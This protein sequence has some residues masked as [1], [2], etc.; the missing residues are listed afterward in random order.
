MMADNN[1]VTGNV[2]SIQRR[3]AAVGREMCIATGPTVQDNKVTNEAI[4]WPAFCARLA[5]PVVTNETIKKYLSADRKT[6]DR[7]K[8]VGYYVFG[9]FKGRRKKENLEFRDA[10]TLDLDHLKPGWRSGL[11]GAFKGLTYAIHSTHKH[12]PEAPRLRQV[13]PLTR[14]VTSEEYEPIARKLAQRFDIN[15]YDKTTFQYNRVMHWPSH[16][17]DAEYI[18]E[19]FGGA[20]VDPDEILALY[21]D[22]TDVD[23]WPAHDGV[24]VSHQVQDLAPD[25]R[26]KHG[27]VGAFCRAFSISEAMDKFIPD[28]YEA[29]TKGRYSYTGGTTSNGAVTYENDLFLYSHHETD[30]CSG[31]LVNAF[32]MVRLHLYGELDGRTRDDTPI[33]KKP[34]YSALVTMLQADPEISRAVAAERAKMLRDEFDAFDL[35]GEEP[36][37]PMIP[38][39]LSDLL[40]DDEPPKQ[41]VDDLLGLDDD[42]DSPK[43]TTGY[44]PEVDGLPDAITVASAEI[45]DPQ[46]PEDWEAQLAVERS[47]LFCN[48]LS[49]VALILAYD[50]EWGHNVRFN[51]FGRFH[52]M[53]KPLA[54]RSK[55][56]FASEGARVN[57]SVFSDRDVPQVKLMLEKKYGMVKIPT[58]MVFGAVE[59]VGTKNRFHPVLSYFSSLPAWDGKPRMESLLI[60]YLGAADNEYTRAV[61]RKVLCAAINRVK[62]PGSKWDYLLILEGLQGVRKGMFLS[63]LSKNP[64]WFAEGL[65]RDL[66]EKAVENMM[67]KWI[68]ELP[69]GEGL[70]NRRSDD[71]LKAF[72]SRS[73]DRMR[74]KYGRVALDFPRQCIFVMTTNRYQYLTDDTGHRRFWPV[75]CDMKRVGRATVDIAKLS[76]EVD[77]IWAE[78]LVYWAKGEQLWLD[79]HLEAMAQAEQSMREM[80]DGLSGRIDTWLNEAVAPGQDGGEF[81]AP[82]GVYAVRNYTCVRQIWSECF[83]ETETKLTRLWSNQIHEAMNRL[84]GW[85]YRPD[86]RKD[87]EGYGR[88]RCFV[89]IG[90][91]VE[92]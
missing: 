44:D 47:G 80:D 70:I 86:I 75:R 18:H 28:A 60:D 31:R 30:P 72:L 39:S 76:R 1:K 71:E 10:I 63:T 73:V 48:T 26:T 56:E 89:R 46:T 61:T 20:W 52:A 15:I 59:L 11:T 82:S 54:H 3:T 8:D 2:V 91:G 92:P 14:R 29:G 53:T 64:S 81:D 65:G 90:S 4:D 37:Y 34:S 43:V 55:R 69:E 42:N 40:G 12:T 50:D 17:R 19:S 88:Q 67:A 21:D 79:P 66:G 78:A 16:S 22:W 41:G 32:D 74:P 27:W 33:Y 13:F 77:Q 57:G 83:G 51:E 25:P 45:I 38:A 68:C 58:E 36:E 9:R 84:S 23:E 7:I 62:N 5:E 24:H 85:E 6:Q 87:F 49:N 35:S